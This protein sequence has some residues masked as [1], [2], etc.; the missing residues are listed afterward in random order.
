M[1]RL[2][3]SFRLYID[4]NKKISPTH[5]AQYRNLVRLFKRFIELLQAPENGSLK[6]DLV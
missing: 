6:A 3:D 5:K 4:R 2:Y 1:F